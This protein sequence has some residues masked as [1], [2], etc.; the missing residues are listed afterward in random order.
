MGF[1]RSIRFPRVAV[2]QVLDEMP[3]AFRGGSARFRCRFLIAGGQTST[4][5]TCLRLAG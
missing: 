2:P 1:N 3:E 5:A 4:R